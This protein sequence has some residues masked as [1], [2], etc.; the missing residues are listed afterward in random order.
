MTQF[1]QGSDPSPSSFGSVNMMYSSDKG[2]ITSMVTHP[3]LPEMLKRE[4]IDVLPWGYQ[5]VTH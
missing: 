4:S 1:P 3:H 5:S 2:P